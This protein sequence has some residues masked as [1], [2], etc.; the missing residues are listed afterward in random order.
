MALWTGEFD[1]DFRVRDVGERGDE[2]LCDGDEL[3]GEGVDD[4]GLS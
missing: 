3:G 1:F 4:D 2:G